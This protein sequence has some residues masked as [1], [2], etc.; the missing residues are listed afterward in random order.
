MVQAS[1][2]VEHWLPDSQPQ[3]ACLPGQICV[4]GNEGLV[5]EPADTSMKLLMVEKAQSKLA[6]SVQPYI[7]DPDS[8]FAQFCQ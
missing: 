1:D 7:R 8:A 5:V 4:D 3:V 2:H 6:C